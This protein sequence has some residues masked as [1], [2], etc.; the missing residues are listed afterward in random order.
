L[1]IAPR[2]QLGSMDPRLSSDATKTV[3]QDAPQDGHEFHA[4]DFPAAG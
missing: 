2:K 1:Q 3:S 4:A